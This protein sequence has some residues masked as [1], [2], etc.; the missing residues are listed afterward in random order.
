[1]KSPPPPSRPA[2]LQRRTMSTQVVTTGLDGSVADLPMAP[3]KKKKFGALR[4][5]FGIHD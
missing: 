3:Q 2:M 1:M 5:M 4:K